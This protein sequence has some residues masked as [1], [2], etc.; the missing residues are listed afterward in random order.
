MS[1]D[2]AIKAIERFQGGS[3]TKSIAKFEAGIVGANS[4][5]VLKLCMRTEVQIKR[6][7]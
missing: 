4:A 5:D 3:L 2:K 7:K 6:P 1:I